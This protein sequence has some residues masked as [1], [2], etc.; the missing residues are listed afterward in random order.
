MAQAAFS[1]SIT[2]AAPHQ[3]RVDAEI[4]SLIDWVRAGI[5][6]TADDY[7]SVSASEMRR[8]LSNSMREVEIILD[9]VPRGQDF[10]RLCDVRARIVELGNSLGRTAPDGWADQLMMIGHLLVTGSDYT[11][12]DAPDPFHHRA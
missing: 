6:D 10:S 2:L 3:W 1:P 9:R 5:V 8:I 4:T 11:D 7:F 12:G